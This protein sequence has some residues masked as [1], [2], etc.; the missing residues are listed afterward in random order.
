[1]GRGLG[2]RGPHG[3]L[4]CHDAEHRHDGLD[5]SWPMAARMEFIRRGAQDVK[6][7]GIYSNIYEK[8]KAFGEG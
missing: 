7:I 1:M 8:K 3:L 6:F 5:T 4:R 2:L